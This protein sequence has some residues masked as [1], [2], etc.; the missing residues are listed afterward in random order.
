MWVPRKEG[1]VFKFRYGFKF[2][3]FKYNANLKKEI[4][5]NIKQKLIR[6]NINSKNV[7]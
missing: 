4:E 3:E 5:R 1:E 7:C 6:T 2:C